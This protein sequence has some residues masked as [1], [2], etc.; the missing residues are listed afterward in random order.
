LAIAAGPLLPLAMR[1]DSPMLL[2]PRITDDEMD[3]ELGWHVG[4]DVTQ[5]RAPS[6]GLPPLTPSSR[7]SQDFVSEF[8]GRNT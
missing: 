5:I 6:C 2:S 3:V 7:N 4:L 8:P 1:I